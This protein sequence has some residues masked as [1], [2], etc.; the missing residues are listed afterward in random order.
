M[1]VTGVLSIRPPAVDSNSSSSTAPS[2]TP[3]CKLVII[4]HIAELIPEAMGVSSDLRV[5]ECP[6]YI[7]VEHV[8][9]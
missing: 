7:L 1:L 8:L 4:H 5:Q 9:H 6:D 2:W 3:T